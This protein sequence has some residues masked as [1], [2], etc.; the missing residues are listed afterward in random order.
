MR[1]QIVLA[2]LVLILLGGLVSWA[3]NFQRL[4]VFGSYFI[5]EAQ[6]TTEAV[7]QSDTQPPPTGSNQEPNQ[8][9][10]DHIGDL[11]KRVDI[12]EAVKASLQAWITILIVTITA[13]ASANVGLSVWQVGSITRRE[14]ENSL[15]DYDNK[16]KEIIE[17]TYRDIDERLSSCGITTKNIAELAKKIEADLGKDNDR[18]V[19]AI[20]EIQNEGN[21]LLEKIKAEGTIIKNNMMNEL[22]DYHRMLVQKAQK[23]D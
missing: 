19:T 20:R 15:K 5:R 4:P 1:R 14:V 17:K 10:E 7:A 22:A 12:L 18:I 6:G 11:V 9:V 2:S 23:E 8:K 16:F 13:L 21:G 3:F